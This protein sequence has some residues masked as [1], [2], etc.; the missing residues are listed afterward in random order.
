MIRNL[1]LCLLSLLP[2]LFACTP[3]VPKDAQ[4]LESHAKTLP[5]YA[6]ATLPPNIAP[7][8][9]RVEED[10]DACIVHF[11]SRKGNRSLVAE[12]KTTDLPADDWKELLQAARGDTLYTDIYVQRKGKWL[13]FPTRRNYVA[14]EE[15][16]PYI[17][18]RLIEPS[19][20]DYEQI[21]ICQRNLTNF[22]EEILCDNAMLT[23]GENGACLNCHAFQDYNRGGRIQMH[24]RQNHGGTLIADGGKLKKVNLKTPQTL[25]AGVYPAWHPRKNLIA[26]SVNETGQVFH[27]RDV[28]KI[29]VLDFASDL[30]LY[31]IDQ[32]KVY[33]IDCKPHDFETFP[34]WSPDGKMLYYCSAHY[35]QTMN[36]IDAELG[37]NYRQM[38]YSILRRPFDE[39]AGKFG[40]QD[41]VFNAA[42]LGKSA[43]LPRI[44]PDGQWLLFSM[45]DFGNFHV[46]HKSSDLYVM[47]LSTGRAYP[48]QEANSQETDSYHSWSSNGR[49]IL[50][51]SRRDD[52]NYTRLYIA[53]FDKTGRAHRAFQVPQRDPLFYARFC[54]SY[55]VPEWLSEPV[56]FSRNELVDAAL[57][58]AVPAEYGG[59][60]LSVPDLRQKKTEPTLPTPNE[61]RGRP[62]NNRLS[63]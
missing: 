40:A 48:L 7:M 13:K 5:D 31:D 1:K 23:D 4:P 28:Q 61:G 15:I 10:A 26:Y 19:Y 3:D 58:E 57:E 49:W 21:L 9:F 8:N 44:S 24:I 52:G 56:A 6:G 12:G 38:K 35:V 55:N 30:I 63:Y 37:L 34:A 59:S 17:A 60:A 45:A 14:Q 22:K 25:S 43:I 42:A 51:T 16:D 2:A 47:N 50:F 53:Y 36:D 29:E 11:H 27:T 46:W 32:N 20:V 54:K 18:Y 41:T 62:V 33:D 39:A